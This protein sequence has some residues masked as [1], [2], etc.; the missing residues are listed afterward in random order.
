MSSSQ[1]IKA[2]LPYLIEFSVTSTFGIVVFDKFQ[3]VILI[4]LWLWRDFAVVCHLLFVTYL[5]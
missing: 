1:T 5:I 4:S 2:A 3:T